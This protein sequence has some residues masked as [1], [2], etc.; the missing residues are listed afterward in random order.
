MSK[1]G[2]SES[3]GT[4]SGNDCS[5]DA[6]SDILYASPGALSMVIVLYLKRP[7]GRLRLSM[8]QDDGERG[9]RVQP[10]GPNFCRVA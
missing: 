9:W 1:W 5:P 10:Q 3:S 8:H 7:R 2:K 4:C 6:S